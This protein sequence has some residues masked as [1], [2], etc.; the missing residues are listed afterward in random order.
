MRYDNGG[1]L[2]HEIL[3]RACAVLPIENANDG[4]IDFILSI[5]DIN[6]P[7]LVVQSVRHGIAPLV[8]CRL[9]GFAHDPRLPA[10]VS[11]CLERMYGANRHRNQVM[12]REA[13]RLVRA[14]EAA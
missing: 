3:L 8:A 13:A 12:F 14:F 6:W 7:E 9:R 1:L 11:A 2:P 5:P 10:D 4:A